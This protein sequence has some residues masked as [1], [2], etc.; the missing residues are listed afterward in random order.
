MW[1]LGPVGVCVGVR[2][3]TLQGVKRNGSEG[4][5]RDNLIEEKEKNVVWRDFEVEEKKKK[6]KEKEK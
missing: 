3:S 6:V 4:E 2:S 5:N 1:N